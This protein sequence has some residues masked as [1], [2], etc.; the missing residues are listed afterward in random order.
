MDINI[1]KRIKWYKDQNNF[2]NAIFRY[3]FKISIV[4]NKPLQI[5]NKS[6]NLF[7]ISR[8]KSYSINS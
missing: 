2:S 5:K 6:N 8:N 3:L 1:I 7:L 4:T